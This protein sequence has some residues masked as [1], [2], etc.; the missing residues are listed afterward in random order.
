M[1]KSIFEK[2]A[3]GRK[4]YT[5][6]QTAI[7]EY[8]IDSIPHD[9]MRGEAYKAPCL[10]ELDV[11]EHFVGLATKNGNGMTNGEVYVQSIIDESARLDGLTG[12]HPYQ[13]ADAGQ[14]AF[15]LLFTLR[16]M[17]SDML[18]MDDVS[19]GAVRAKQTLDAVL[20]MTKAY[21][22]DKKEKRSTVL[23][24]A[25]AC[26]C[27]AKAVEAA[28]FT[29][30]RVEITLDGVKAAADNDVALL[31]VR[32]PGL[33]GRFNGEI[34]EIVDAIHGVGGLC[35]ADVSDMKGYI[36]ITRPGDVGF[37]A[38]YFGLAELFSISDVKGGDSAYVLGVG[39]CLADYIP[40][41]VVE[42]DELEQYYF[43]YNRPKSVGKMNEFYGNFTAWIKALGYILSL[44][45]EGLVD[46][47][48]AVLLNT[49]YARANDQKA[50]VSE[51]ADKTRIDG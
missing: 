24:G 2:G 4:G 26:P 10:N 6:P 19:M 16:H 31:L 5:L 20:L 21:Y 14:G 40:T 18:G 51:A 22:A 48:K 41:P 12:I 36:G 25:K 23:I 34:G 33:D 15:E 17:L 28:G 35:A 49:R 44:G 30:K 50:R 46:V 32:N 3:C 45:F 1:I 43:D 38:I 29:V 42:M 9:L 39:N 13:L 47:S 27:V 11:A 7:D 37:D 8:T